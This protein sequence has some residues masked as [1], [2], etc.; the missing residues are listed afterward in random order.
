MELAKFFIQL[1]GSSENL[2]GSFVAVYVVITSLVDDKLGVV[3]SLLQPRVVHLPAH[4]QSVYMQSVLKMFGQAAS[5]GSK[6]VHKCIIGGLTIRHLSL[7]KMNQKLMN[8]Q[9]PIQRSMTSL[10]S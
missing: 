8:P 1:L 9:E 6:S 4:I 5:G 2:Q 7:E 3:E 10:K